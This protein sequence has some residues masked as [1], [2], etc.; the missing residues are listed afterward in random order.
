MVISINDSDE[1]KRASFRELE[2]LRA[3][4]E[5][6]KTTAA[7]H[8]LGI[9][10]PAISRAIAKL[11]GKVGRSL[12]ERIG[13]RLSPTADAL[14]LN[15]ELEPIFETLARINNMHWGKQTGSV[16]KIATAPTL[17][18]RFVDLLLADFM[19]QYPDVDVVLEI[20]ATPDIVASIAQ[21]R[22]SVGISDS[23][24]FHPAVQLHPFR[25]ARA[26][27]LLPKGSALAAKETIE[28]S[29][30][31][32]QNFI[33]LAKTHS[34]GATVDS[35]LRN[36]RVTVR[37]VV[38]TVTSVSALEFVKHGLG[39]TVINPFPVMLRRDTQDIVLKPFSPQIVQETSFITAVNTPLSPVASAF[40]AF[41]RE[42]QPKDQF[43]EII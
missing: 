20:C 16:L 33:A 1:E 43:S 38:E 31:Q 39:A 3:L 27:C 35:I 10:Q 26:V 19:S 22:A 5:E 13:G 40:M 14:A 4:I 12:F 11:E 15:Q 32:G 6:R 7:A 41:V 23:K 21:Q 24:V 34:L 28:P 42:H 18:H 30:L 37:N 17:A 9:S 2:I 29:D 25:R 36:H 8:A